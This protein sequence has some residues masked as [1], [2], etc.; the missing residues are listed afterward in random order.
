MRPTWLFLGLFASC[1]RVPS[2]DKDTEADADT[3]ADAD[4]DTDADTDTDTD[5]DP[6]VECG[7]PPKSGPWWDDHPFTGLA[8]QDAL[9]KTDAGL[10]AV[11][12]A[13]SQVTELTVLTKPIEVRGAVVTFTGYRP[14][15]GDQLEV[16]VAD[17]SRGLYLRYV[18]VP[19][20]VGLEPSDIVDFDVHVVNNYGGLGQV[21]NETTGSGSDIQVVT[22]GVQ[23][24][25]IT[26]KAPAVWVV[27]AAVEAPL[28][29]ND[30]G[31][32]IIEAYGEILDEGV[33]CP[34]PSFCYE[35]E[36]AEGQTATF[37]SR[38]EFIEQGDCLH[39]V[40]PMGAF[41]GPQIDATT[42]EWHRTY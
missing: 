37:R 36:Y 21:V 3:D 11:R 1:S 35:F 10:S 20:S 40:G 19:A 7:E 39:Y 31:H 6:V 17:F 28:T 26:G 5:T 22:E 18:T 23:N 38:S 13:G 41:N 30:H 25:T 34:E 33:G 14:G 12:D 16:W 42:Y 29:V 32:A 27:D 8:I 15:G 9:P 24:L 2:D 4:A